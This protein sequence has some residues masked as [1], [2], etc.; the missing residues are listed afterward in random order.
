MWS[1]ETQIRYRLRSF[2]N[3]VYIIA[4][5]CLWRISPG[6]PQGSPNPL[7]LPQNTGVLQFRRHPEL[8]Q[9]SCREVCSRPARP[10]CPLSGQGPLSASQQVLLQRVAPQNHKPTLRRP[11]PSSSQNQKRRRKCRPAYGHHLGACENAEHQAHP[12]HTCSESSILIRPLRPSSAHWSLRSTSMSTQSVCFFLV[13][14][15][16]N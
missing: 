7:R 9:L 2:F 6:E 4:L 1:S 10:R 15:F 16:P 13:K 8:G 12:R 11:S 3:L 5:W 14:A